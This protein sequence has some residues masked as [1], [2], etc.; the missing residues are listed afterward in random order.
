[1]T[2]TLTTA[3]YFYRASGEKQRS[4]SADAGAEHTV[5]PSVQMSYHWSARIHGGLNVNH[6]KSQKHIDEFG[7]NVYLQKHQ[8][9]IQ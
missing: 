2:P 3:H 5:L 8:N 4:D 1:M 6:V 9:L 7:R